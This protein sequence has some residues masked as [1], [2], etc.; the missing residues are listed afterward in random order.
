MADLTPTAGWAESPAS[1]P[2]PGSAATAAPVR[3]IRWRF[4]LILAAAML[5][6]LVG[7]VGVI[8]GWAYHRFGSLG[9]AAAF[10]R[11]NSL[12][13]EPLTLDAGPLRP[14]E[15]RTLRLWACNLTGQVLHVNGGRGYCAREACV[16]LEDQ[17][18]LAIAPRSRR[19]IR[20]HVEANPPERSRPGPFRYQTIIYTEVGGRMV[21]ITGSAIGTDVSKD[22]P[23]E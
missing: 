17:F 9:A 19:E 20:I 13:L 6:P 21:A 23:Q 10:L 7:G 3:R 12:V 15:A 8:G 2:S 22:R 5:T 4:P 11:G 16:A 1:L 18:P 14:G